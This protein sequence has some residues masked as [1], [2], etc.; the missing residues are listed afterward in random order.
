MKPNIVSLALAGVALAMAVVSIVLS[1]LGEISVKDLGIF[2]GVGLFVLAI[3][4][5]IRTQKR[6][7]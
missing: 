3:D 7:K 4:F 5:L 1:S 2:L 6:N